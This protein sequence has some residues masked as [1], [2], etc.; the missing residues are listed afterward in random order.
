MSEFAVG[1]VRPILLEVSE[2]GEKLAVAVVGTTD[3]GSHFGRVCSSRPAK[4]LSTDVAHACHAFGALVVVDFLDWCRRTGTPDEW[5]PPIGGMLLGDWVTMESVDVV[6]MAATAVAQ[7]ALY[8]APQVDGEAESSVSATPRTSE[9]ARFLEN[10]R[11]QVTLRRP[12]LQRGFRKHFSL[13]GKDVGSEIDFVGSRYATCYAAVN[14]RAKAGVRLQTASAALWRLARAR[15]AFGFASPQAV[16]LTAWV[17]PLGQPIFSD[18][19]Y[20]VV[21]EMVAE[22]TAQARREDLGVF[23]ATDDATASARLIA[24]EVPSD[25]V[26]S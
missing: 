21:D 22:L 10:I 3:D 11:Q 19:D 6:T 16:E 12:S 2:W 9:E 1:T 23:T 15:D 8:V 25:A 24:I 13:T 18:R 4:G 20:E 17:P 7:S 26:L 5:T 14:P